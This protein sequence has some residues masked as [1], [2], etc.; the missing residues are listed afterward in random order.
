MKTSL[1]LKLSCCTGSLAFLLCLSMHVPSVWSL[2]F[3]SDIGSIVSGHQTS[4]RT[5]WLG[6][7]SP[8][9]CKPGVQKLGI[10]LKGQG[11]C[12]HPLSLLFR[13][14][15]G[16]KSLTQDPYCRAVLSKWG[17]RTGSYT[18]LSADSSVWAR[19]RGFLQSDVLY[20]GIPLQ[21]YGP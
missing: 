3:P 2:L 10:K 12:L 20:S 19:S 1:Q 11:H 16:S 18:F 13:R 6:S 17:T 8:S 7:H 14:Q 9:P 4:W 21:A 15:K 5:R